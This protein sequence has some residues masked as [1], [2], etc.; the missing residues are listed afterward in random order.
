MP[1]KAHYGNNK[2]FYSILFV[3]LLFYLQKGSNYRD[4]QCAILGAKPLP[5]Y[6]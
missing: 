2:L 4:F 5:L 3:P 1:I 6:S